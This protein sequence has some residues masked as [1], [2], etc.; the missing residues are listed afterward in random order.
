MHCSACQASP[1][2]CYLMQQVPVVVVYAPPMCGPPMC[3]PPMCGPSRC[4]PVCPPPCQASELVRYA[5][6]PNKTA[7]DTPIMRAVQ[8]FANDCSACPNCDTIQVFSTGICGTTVAACV[9]LVTGLNAIGLGISLNLSHISRDLPTPSEVH[10]T[11]IVPQTAGPD[12]TYCQR[13]CLSQS[14][15][16]LPCN[17]FSVKFDMSDDYPLANFK[18]EIKLVYSLF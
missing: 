17:V 15:A 10:V 1:C 3:G 7:R 4:G 16:N 14:R 8:L 5:H 2:V 9:P 6:D 11:V 18:C 13:E 12:K